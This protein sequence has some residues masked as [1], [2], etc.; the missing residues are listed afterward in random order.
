V[1]R[2]REPEDEPQAAPRVVQERRA[3]RELLAICRQADALLGAFSCPKSGECCRLAQTRREPF[4]LPLER[5]ALVQALARQGRPMPLKRPDGACALLDASGL[6]C[7]I[8]PDRP[9]GCRTFFCARGQGRSV[10]S[11]ALHALSA[12]LT[13]ASDGLEADGEPTPISRL[14]GS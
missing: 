5:L 4:L 10:P 8:Y 7:S 6:R 2:R 9:F 14:F 13:R 3:L 11:A 1:A 12:R